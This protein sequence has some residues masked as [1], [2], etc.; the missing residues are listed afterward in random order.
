MQQ[1]NLQEMLINKIEPL[2]QINY[3]YV[4]LY[5]VEKKQTETGKEP[6]INPDTKKPISEKPTSQAGANRLPNTG[7]EMLQQI[8]FIWFAILAL[9][10]SCG[11]ILL[12]KKGQVTKEKR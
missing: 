2:D 3:P 4:N 10:I 7:L 11:I 1:Q 5:H 8:H 9:A 6:V 12:R